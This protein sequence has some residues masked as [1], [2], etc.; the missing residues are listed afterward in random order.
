MQDRLLQ[1]GILLIISG[2]SGSGKGTVCK[3]LQPTEGFALSIS[4]T[5]R[6]QRPG[7]VHGIDYIFCDKD[8]FRAVRDADGLLE[9]AMYGN[10][11]YGTPVSYVNDQM[12]NGHTV[13]LEINVVGA[14]Q[15]KEKY[16]E[17]ILIFL[18]P[19]TFSDLRHRLELRGTEDEAEIDR[20][21]RRAWD[22]VAELPKY[23]YL[24]IND[25]VEN[26]VNEIKLIVASEK[27][28]PHRSNEKI[29]H[30]HD[31]IENGE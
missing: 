10:N 28:K 9:H 7:E 27:L 31:N 3:N 30:F 5:T 17:A 24:V 16:P 8:Q 12:R 22:E 4:M 6:T 25:S 15:V 21:F 19:P 20:R 23:D 29:S 11:Y 1:D 13:V 2:P 14:L 18:M 26:A